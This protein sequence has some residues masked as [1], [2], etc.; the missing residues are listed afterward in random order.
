[1]R[2]RAE[3][4]REHLGYPGAGYRNVRCGVDALG[5]GEVKRA[6]G[7]PVGKIQIEIFVI[8]REDEGAI[9]DFEAVESDGIRLVQTNDFAEVGPVRPLSV[10]AARPRA[11]YR[12]S[13]GSSA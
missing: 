3:G 7:N 12:A 8:G 5:V 13:S 9:T 4:C 1:M 6:V 11:A 2:S 10:E